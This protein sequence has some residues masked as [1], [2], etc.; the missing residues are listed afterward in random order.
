MACGIG[1]LEDKRH[2]RWEGGKVGR[3]IGRYLEK[4]G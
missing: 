2:G 4:S 1:G 3:M